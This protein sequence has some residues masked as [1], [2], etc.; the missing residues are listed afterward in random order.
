MRTRFIAMIIVERMKTTT[1]AGQLRLSA[2]AR[3]DENAT[4]NVSSILRATSNGEC[5][6]PAQTRYGRND[7]PHV[8]FENTGQLN[9]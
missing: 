1:A 4:R 9:V 7:K 3:S 5:N 8:I 6:V 2:K